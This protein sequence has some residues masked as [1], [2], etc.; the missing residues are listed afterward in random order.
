[1]LKLMPIIMTF[2]HKNFSRYNLME[3]YWQTHVPKSVKQ[4]S[5]VFNLFNRLIWLRPYKNKAGNCPN[6]TQWVSG[7][8]M[9]TF[10][11]A[12]YPGTT[13]S[14]NQIQVAS[15]TPNFLLFATCVQLWTMPRPNS[16]STF[17]GLPVKSAIE[18]IL[19]SENGNQTCISRAFF[20]HYIS[21]RFEK[22]SLTEFKFFPSSC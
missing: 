7:C 5:I 8:H 12:I 13:C 14:Q 11:H 18:F 21:K 19:D 16:P 17:R 2:F 10:R 3:L 15:D 22:H 4:D 1:M 9:S 6:N 20:R